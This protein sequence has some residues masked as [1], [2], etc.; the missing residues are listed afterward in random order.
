MLERSNP[1]KRH[2]LGKR[3]QDHY[4]SLLASEKVLRKPGGFSNSLEVTGAG[5]I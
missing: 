2:T 1:A 3:P 5:N 4:A